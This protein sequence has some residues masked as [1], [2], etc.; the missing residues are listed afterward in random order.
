M[1]TEA[2]PTSS[3]T[4]PKTAKNLADLTSTER[5]E[6][7]ETLRQ[8]EAREWIK[9]YRKKAMEEGKTKA[10]DW[11]SRN[12]EKLTKKRG[13][14]AADDLRKRMNDETRKEG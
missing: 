14:H 1:N 9:R 10:L 6:M 4:E 7:Q 12:L 13:Q 5:L 11:W 8:C 3:L 2:L